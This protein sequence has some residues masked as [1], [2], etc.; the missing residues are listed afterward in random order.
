MLLSCPST[1]FNLILS[2]K[3]CNISNLGCFT[4]DFSTPWPR[5]HGSQ[6]VP[7]KPLDNQLPQSKVYS[8]VSLSHW[9]GPNPNINGLGDSSD[10]SDRS[11]DSQCH[12][13]ICIPKSFLPP[14]PSSLPGRKASC[15]FNHGRL[16][17]IWSETSKASNPDSLWMAPHC[18]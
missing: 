2:R 16:L 12:A 3:P 18:Q 4:S 8:A 1:L 13:F 6:H 10:I 14:F 17:S 11:I 7:A 15:L 5:G 9:L